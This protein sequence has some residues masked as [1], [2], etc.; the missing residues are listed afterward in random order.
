MVAINELLGAMMSLQ[1]GAQRATS[2]ILAQL[3]RKA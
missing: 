3:V 1:V 2:W